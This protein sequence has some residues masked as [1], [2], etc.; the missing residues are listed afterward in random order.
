MGWSTDEMRLW[1]LNDEGLYLVFRRIARSMS[2]KDAAVELEAV[3]RDNKMG[4]KIGVN[5]DKVN[6]ES[7]AKTMKKA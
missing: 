1:A 7:I 5:L 2:L 6:W 3:A 4:E